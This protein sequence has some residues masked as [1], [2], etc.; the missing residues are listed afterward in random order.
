[1]AWTSEDDAS[2]EDFADFR[3]R[4]RHEDE[5]SE[6][7]QARAQYVRSLTPLDGECNFGLN[8]SLL[9]EFS[10]PGTAPGPKSVVDPNLVF[11]Q[12]PQELSVYWKTGNVLEVMPVGH[13]F[14]STSYRIQIASSVVNKLEEDS[15]TFNFHTQTLRVRIYSRASLDDPLRPIFRI[16]P[17]QTVDSE[18]LLA[19]L[20]LTSRPKGVAGFLVSSVSRFQRSTHTFELLSKS[21]EAIEVTPLGPLPPDSV[22]ELTLAVGSF[23]LEGPNASEEAFV[24]E[25]T[26][27]PPMTIVSRFPGYFQKITPGDSW[28]INFA[29][30]LRIPEDRL[31]SMVE[32]VPKVPF[33]V[34]TSFDS[35]M[36]ITPDTE[37]F[38]TYK[39]TLSASIGDVY[40]QQLNT[41]DSFSFTTGQ[42]PPF[43]GSIKGQNDGE[44]ILTHFGP[45]R[46]FEYLQTNMSAV[47]ERIFTLSGDETPGL[48]DDSPDDTIQWLER[49]CKCASDLIRTYGHATSQWGKVDW[50]EVLPGYGRIAV[51][52]EPSGEKL[53]AR[54]EAQGHSRYKY[55]LTCIIQSTSLALSAVSLAGATML[56]VSKLADGSPVPKALVREA[57]GGGKLGVSDASGVL[58]VARLPD[59]RV[60]AISPSDAKDMCIF[61]APSTSVEDL[62]KNRHAACAFAMDHESY[63]P[64]ETVSMCI[65]ARTR[66][67]PHANVLGRF[68]VGGLLNWSCLYC[69]QDDEESKEEDAGRRLAATESFS[70]GDDDDDDSGEISDLESEDFDAHTVIATGA[71]AFSELS[72]VSLSFQLPAEA[73]EGKYVLLCR[74]DIE[75]WNERNVLIGAKFFRIKKHLV[76]PFRC[77]TSITALSSKLPAVQNAPEECMAIATVTVDMQGGGSMSGAQVK[78]TATARD[79]AIQVPESLWPMYSFGQHALSEAPRA[80]QSTAGPILSE[81]NDSGYNRLVLAWSGREACDRPVQ[82]DVNV[83]VQDLFQRSTMSHASIILANSSGPLLGL[84][85]ADYWIRQGTSVEIGV[86]AISRSD[87]KHVSDCSIVISLGLVGSSNALMSVTIESRDENEVTT[88]FCPKLFGQYWV[89]A[90]CGM[91]RSSTSLF[92]VPSSVVS[93]S[94]RENR[95]LPASEGRPVSIILNRRYEAHEFVAGDEIRVAVVVP[96]MVSA[97]G[98]LV[99]VSPTSGTVVHHQH[100]QLDEFGAVELLMPCDANWFPSV[101]LS[102]SVMG[103]SS[104]Q[105]NDMPCWGTSVTS[106]R[107]SRRAQALSI[108][109]STEMIEA[110]H[111]EIHCRILDSKDQPV[112][113]A[114]AFLVG[115]T[116][117][118]HLPRLMES[119]YPAHE[120][121]T[122]KTKDLRSSIIVQKSISMRAS[123]ASKAALDASLV[124]GA[125]GAAGQLSSPT[126]GDGSSDN[127]ANLSSGTSHH[128]NSGDDPST[129]DSRLGP[130]DDV[131]D[132][133]TSAGLD[134]T[135]SIFEGTTTVGDSVVEDSVIEVLDNLLTEGDKEIVF[136]CSQFGDLPIQCFGAASLEAFAIKVIRGMTEIGERVIPAETG[137]HVYLVCR[138]EMNVAAACAAEKGIVTESAFAFL[139]GVLDD[140]LKTKEDERGADLL[141]H[142]LHAKLVKWNSTAIIS[143]LVTALKQE[144]ATALAH[145]APVFWSGVSKRMH[146]VAVEPCN[147]LQALI[148][149]GARDDSTWTLFDAAQEETDSNGALALPLNLTDVHKN[150]ALC[151]YTILVTSKDD[152]I[153]LYDGSIIPSPPVQVA[154]SCPD[155]VRIGDEFNVVVSVQ[156][157]LQESA[158]VTIR[159]DT[160]FDSELQLRGESNVF[161]VTLS[162]EQATCIVPVTF[163]ALMGGGRVESCSGHFSVS[164]QGD[165]SLRSVEAKCPL[166]ILRPSQEDDRLCSRLVVAGSL[167]PKASS[168]EDGVERVSFGLSF[169]K[170]AVESSH[171]S[172]GGIEVKLSNSPFVFLA[173]AVQSFLRAGSEIVD[174]LA[175]RIL[176]ICAVYPRLN[177]LGLEEFGG[178]HVGDQLRADAKMV[179]KLQGALG[180]FGFWS[181]HSMSSAFLSSHAAHA[182]WEAQRVLLSLGATT[183]AAT[184]IPTAALDRCRSFVDS[185]SRTPVSSRKDVRARAYATYVGVKMG[186]C[187]VSAAQAK[188]VAMETDHGDLDTLGWLLGSVCLSAILHQDGQAKRPASGRFSSLWGL[189]GGGS[190]NVNKEREDA[191]DAL[192]ERVVDIFDHGSTIIDGEEAIMADR[193]VYDPDYLHSEGRAVSVAL[194]GLQ[195]AVSEMAAS[196]NKSLVV[197]QHLALMSEKL[198]QMSERILGL[199]WADGTWASLHESAFA[200]L[201]LARYYIAHSE[202]EVKG[203]TTE[204]ILYGPETIPLVGKSSRQVHIPWS[205]LSAAGNSELTLIGSGSHYVVGVERLCRNVGSLR[206]ASLPGSAHETSFRLSRLFESVDAKGDVVYDDMQQ[207][208][209]VKAGARIRVVLRFA[210]QNAS[211]V[212]LVDELCAGFSIND[213]RHLRAV[214]LCAGQYREI[215]EDHH[216]LYSCG[217]IE[218]FADR[219]TGSSKRTFCYIAHASEKGVFVVPPAHVSERYSPSSMGRSAGCTVTIE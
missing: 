196:G 100:F 195:L 101:K 137:Q 191:M 53:L 96:E 130:E 177:C 158:N 21:S 131:R 151:N 74:S 4:A 114:E 57:D 161:R 193:H 197:K 42:W 207:H 133:K 55:A 204:T 134:E 99:A 186:A 183:S 156:S 58:L 8:R 23:S 16:V 34:T 113:G 189:F 216:V 179:L 212:A 72:S 180:G 166:T 70:L 22:A 41:P 59:K 176:G 98:L 124:V 194:E 1:M 208:Y 7:F 198:V 5:S 75:S 206:A 27:Y 213:G 62:H 49:N 169:L 36:C 128:G 35:R 117:H 20:S 154:I 119:F 18:K 150:S 10:L 115:G 146:S 116:A 108:A 6:D 164:A 163:R 201:G 170:G 140:L 149:G 144:P 147:E 69:S 120:Q 152:K 46:T 14:G 111:A 199:R 210:C 54:L 125:G 102:A 214:G 86:V 181:R 162:A 71:T 25:F 185:A 9:A 40:G 91:S 200:C 187:M 31:Q 93:L 167:L 83:T 127:T 26:T 129:S 60:V 44:P 32:I 159:V 65:W 52:V 112:V 63:L 56:S 78:W 145:E 2:T 19:G 39:L 192:M 68:N 157:R 175:S 30:N 153:G 3:S 165:D 85:L 51:V 143:E 142:M 173:P 48:D 139:N 118:G 110:A 80:L 188:R 28:R 205:E 122:L 45:N 203:E 121:V 87:F 73:Q 178:Y 94:F 76:A 171:A 12:P 215:W 84:R 190:S 103:P 168:G 43:K 77:L 95:V 97:Y 135:S 184:I 13:W 141:T 182:L 132:G 211:Q 202:D 24:C 219:L 67:P 79:V 47:R 138:R 160:T 38:T 126:S 15:L 81:L 109:C 218:V 33:T 11:C 89:E 92:V 82:I 66:L 29:N 148:A 90:R 104:P 61:V 106:L 172:E 64:G 155:F 17:N 107:V 37:A 105:S 209:K 174:V 50:S 136:I 88:L 123:M 217:R